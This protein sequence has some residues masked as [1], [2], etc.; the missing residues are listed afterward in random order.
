MLPR[1]LVNHISEYAEMT[2]ERARDMQILKIYLL[3]KKRPQAP[4]TVLARLLGI[5]RYAVDY[6]LR[7]AKEL[8]VICDD[9]ADAVAGF[10]RC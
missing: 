7:R 10:E 4:K 3:A 8:L 2:L 6:G 9:F 5:S 1:E